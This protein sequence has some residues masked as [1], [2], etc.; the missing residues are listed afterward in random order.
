M[1]YMNVFLKFVYKQII[2]TSD[3]AVM[4]VLIYFHIQMKKQPRFQWKK[5]LIQE[6][7]VEGI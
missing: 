1:F 7:P 6:Y 4:Q 5:H 2:P 3:T